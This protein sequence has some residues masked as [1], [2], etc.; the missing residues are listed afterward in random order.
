MVCAR[1]C[2]D[3]CLKARRLL[4][5]VRSFSLP[6]GASRNQMHASM[7]VQQVPFP[8]A[9][10]HWPCFAFLRQGADI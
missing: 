10:P 7:P 8:S 5:G 1:T 3:V 4:N 2:H 9:P 6:S